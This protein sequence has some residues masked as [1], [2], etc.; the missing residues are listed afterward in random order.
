MQGT[1][2]SFVCLRVAEGPPK[3]FPCDS[4]GGLLPVWTM[5]NALE[6]QTQRHISQARAPTNWSYYGSTKRGP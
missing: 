5:H 1:E 6:S 4:Q 3:D 2:A